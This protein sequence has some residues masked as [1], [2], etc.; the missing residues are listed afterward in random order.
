MALS[1]KDRDAFLILQSWL[2]SDARECL[3]LPRTVLHRFACLGEP[4]G[5]LAQQIFSP[6]VEQTT[7]QHRRE[8]AKCTIS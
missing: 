8:N 4:A 6:G 7:P 2:T 3:T 1:D 5:K